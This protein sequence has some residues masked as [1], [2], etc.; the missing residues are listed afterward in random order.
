[1]TKNVKPHKPPGEPSNAKDEAP[2][3]RPYVLHRQK[4][5]TT[6]TG[7]MFDVEKKHR[8]KKGKTI[9]ALAREDTLSLDSRKVL[10]DLAKNFVKSCFSR[11]FP[12]PIH[13]E[14]VRLT[15]I[16]LAAFL[17]SLLKDIKSERP[18]IT[19]KD[20]LRLLFITKWF[21]EFF[22]QAHAKEKALKKESSWNFGF[23]ADV[24][25][26]A[27]ITWVLKRMREALDAKV[28]LSAARV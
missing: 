28:V 21:L 23:V 15:R 18:K 22:L 3:P 6:E 11:T 14:P 4:A 17:S 8:T 7:E 26:R 5:L 10:Q 2:P 27:W 25:D 20:N 16:V 13:S 19:E 9:D 24:T 1:V 12:S